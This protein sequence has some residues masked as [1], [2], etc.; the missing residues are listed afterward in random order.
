MTDDPNGNGIHDPSSSS[1]LEHST[2]SHR[3]QNLLKTGCI[4]L[5]AEGYQTCSDWFGNGWLGNLQQTLKLLA[6]MKAEHTLVLGCCEWTRYM[7]CSSER[8]GWP[9][10]LPWPPGKRP[11]VRKPPN[12]PASRR[13]MRPLSPIASAITGPESAASCSD[14]LGGVHAELHQVLCKLIQ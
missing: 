3:W 4:G 12:L 5:L 8:R 13:L 7:P 10:A 1:P 9:G 2:E 14:Y 11:K 6:R